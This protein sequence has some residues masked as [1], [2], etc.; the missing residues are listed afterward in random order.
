MGFILN[1]WLK[2]EN[3]IHTHTHK[4]R[5][6]NPYVHSPSSNFSFYF[7][8][9]QGKKMVVDMKDSLLH[10]FQRFVLVSHPNKRLTNEERTN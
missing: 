4:N 2:G 8:A 10:F 5:F 9:A 6:I 7:H 3:G 1:V